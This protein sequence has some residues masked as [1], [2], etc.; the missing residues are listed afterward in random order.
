MTTME[1]ELIMDYIEEHGMVVPKVP[2]TSERALPSL[3]T[4]QLASCYLEGNQPAEE[5]EEP[6]IFEP[7][8]F[9]END[10]CTI[11]E[12]RPFG[13]RSFGSTVDCGDE[14]TAEAPEWFVSLDTVINQFIEHV[15]RG[16]DW[17]NMIDVLMHLQKDGS[18][19]GQGERLLANKPLPGLLIPPE[20]LE[21]IGGLLARLGC[22]LEGEEALK[23]F[24]G[25]VLE[26]MKK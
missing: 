2:D 21:K 23:E 20:D 26:R 5:V 13:C 4:N 9:L 25:L 24:I 11:Y 10:C 18:V 12:V 22:I 16:G 15:D 17:G 7:C 8:I 14:G 3:T 6:W 1:G 19:S